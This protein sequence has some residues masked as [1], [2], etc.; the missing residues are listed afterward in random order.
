MIAEK[1]GGAKA[2]ALLR[3]RAL[4]KEVRTAEKQVET[5]ETEREQLL[6]QLAQNDSGAD[7]AAIN[8]RLNAMVGVVEVCTFIWIYAFIAHGL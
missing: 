3:K 5:L 6:A 8:R 4:Q 1:A 7:F 2:G